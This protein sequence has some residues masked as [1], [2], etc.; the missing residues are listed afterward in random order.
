MGALLEM[1]LCKLNIVYHYFNV[2]IG[3]QCEPIVISRSYI[4][5]LALYS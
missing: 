5:V 2:I 1:N 3:F 4:F